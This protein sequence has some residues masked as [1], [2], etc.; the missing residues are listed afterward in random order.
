MA[1]PSK[2]L[3]W[4]QG[5]PIQNYGDA[6]SPILLDR[7]A[8][9]PPNE[10]PVLRLVGS[11]LA[12]FVLYSDLGGKLDDPSLTIA[13][14][15]CGMRDP[16]PLAPSLQARLHC[17]G[18]RG[19]L[20]RSI[21]G[22]PG[23]TPIGDPALL[24]PELYHP[25]AS[26]LAGKTICVPHFH[27]TRS[28]D[29][30]LEQTKADAVLRP[31]ITGDEA[32]VLAMTDAIAGASFVLAGALHAAIVACAYGVPFAF[33]D[34][35][36]VDIPFKWLDFSAS[37]GIPAAFP[38]TMQEARIVWQE[39]ISPNLKRPPLLPLLRCFPG[40]VRAS[41]LDNVAGGG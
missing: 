4:L 40:K 2:L 39:L 1:E 7:I 17:Y 6:L 5:E 18:V 16:T 3:Y 8:A 13:C 12:D 20:S 29:A 21:L 34:T 22:L 30:L 31:N 15:G 36:Y 14:W 24:L 35:G 11:V 27:E 23:N 28:D 19:P 32:S 33:L 9:E 38:R 10:H 41:L 25:Q 26:P 37:V